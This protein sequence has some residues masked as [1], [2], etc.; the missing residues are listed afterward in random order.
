M[1]TMLLSFAALQEMPDNSEAMKKVDWIVGAWEGTGK[2]EQFGESTES[3]LIEPTL[4][5]NFLRIVQ[6]VRGGDQVIWHSTG[7]LGWDTQKK[8]FVWFQFGLDGTLGW[9]RTGGDDVAGKMVMEG[10]LT[11]GGPFASFRTTFTK[12]GDDTMSNR[13]EFKEGEELALFAATDYKKLEKAPKEEEVKSEDAGHLKRMEWVIGTWMGEG[14]FNGMKYED[15]HAYSWAHSGNFIKNEYWMRV[16]GEVAWHDMG[17]MGYDVDRKKFVGI[18]F[19]IDGTIGWGEGDPVE[20][21]TFM[22][23]GD[24]VGPSENIKFRTTVTKV[25]ADTMKMNI[26]KRDGDGWAPYMPE[27]TKKRKK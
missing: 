27:Q 22:W 11:G 5:G 14:E 24:T 12:T 17:L 19:G 21:D 18:N 10:Q 25:D 2:S 4:K 20:G 9:V 7:L 6:T 1:M 16:G 26:E 8:N 23:E 3:L 13:L 15:E